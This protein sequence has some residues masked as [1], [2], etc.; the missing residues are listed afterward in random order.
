MNDEAASEIIQKEY[1][2]KL[3]GKRM[4]HVCYDM[5]SE[6]L[7]VPNASSFTK[8]QM[9]PLLQ[10][11]KYYIVKNSGDYKFMN[12]I[13]GSPFSSL[14]LRSVE[15]FGHVYK[16]ISE[17]IKGKIENITVVEANL[18]RMPSTVKQLP[19][20]YHNNKNYSGG[21]I[22]SETYSE[23]TFIDEFDIKGKHRKNNINLITVKTPFIL[24]DI[25]PIVESSPT[26]KEWAVLDGY[27][28][29]H[30]TR[31]NT[32][33]SYSFAP[34]YA[35]KQYLYFGWP[36]EEVCKVMLEY[37]NN[38]GSLIKGISDLLEVAEKLEKDGYS[39]PATIPY[40]I[41]FKIDLFD[42]P[43]DF[44]KS[45]MQIPFFKIMEYDYETKYIIIKTP[46]Y[47]DSNICY[48]ILKAKSRPFVARYNK[49]IDKIDVKVEDGIFKE[50]DL[51]TNIPTK[52]RVM[53]ALEMLSNTLPLV[54]RSD[55]RSQAISQSSNE[56]SHLRKISDYYYATEFIKKMCKN[57][58]VEFE[59]ISVLV[60]PL[61]RIFG[62]GVQGGFMG[63]KEFK[64]SKIKIP[65]QIEKGLWVT[66]PLIAV[67]SDSMPSYAAQ[68]E[69][70]IH[71]YSHKIYSIQHPY[72]EHLY[73]KGKKSDQG[74]YWDLYLSDEDE[75]L[76]HKEEIRFELQSGKS[77]DEI[78][79]DKVGG[80]ITKNSYSKNYV[81]ALKFKQI[82]DEVVM[83]MENEQEE[84]YE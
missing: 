46:A 51:T 71:E 84:I 3:S 38:F 13:E 69:T 64:N 6:M 17:N 1:N 37:A 29:F 35:A 78:V 8:E 65:H 54:F 39:N 20:I 36:F 18:S 60:G 44:N 52:I 22:D 82:V 15:S 47:I 11:A 31:N 32:D 56:L 79:R 28:Q 74:K 14:R 59:D 77:V 21:L 58:G 53:I 2:E 9:E 43:Y 76:A 33:E 83:E 72:H 34:L 48:K 25:S 41:S 63:E 19:S 16:T 49:T 40:Y 68:T 12:P 24:I 73:N 62:S 57:R 26:A 42:F 75:R 50:L 5:D 7:Y 27:R 66:P 70:L 45:D 81:T 67:N 55:K 80:A 10:A 4:L 61:E 23:I 30:M